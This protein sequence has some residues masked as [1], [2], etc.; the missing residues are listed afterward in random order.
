[1]WKLNQGVSV[2]GQTV[3]G[4]KYLFD[5]RIQ[6]DPRLSAAIRVWPFETG[7]GSPSDARIVAAE[8][9][10]SILPI[11]HDLASYVKD[12]AQVLTCVR[13]AARRDAIG[14]LAVSFGEPAGVHGS[15]LRA[16]GEEEGWIL[17][18]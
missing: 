13:H 15:E 10:P 9:F 8:I 18:M 7:W 6:S 5:L 1:V 3:L 2:G 4:L 16:V 17:F 12:Q 11:D 14:N